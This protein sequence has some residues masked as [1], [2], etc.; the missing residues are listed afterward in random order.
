[1]GLRW[2]RAPAGIARPR[3]LR[4][5]MASIAVG[6]AR[7]LRPSCSIETPAAIASPA[8]STKSRRIRLA[9]FMFRFYGSRA[10][11]AT[12]TP[13]TLRRRQ[14]FVGIASNLDRGRPLSPPRC[15]LAVSLVRYISVPWLATPALAT[16]L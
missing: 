10:V 11:F 9:R 3:A 16:H 14:K 8:A 2:L 7:A 6:V 5:N 15:E 1:M 12:A 13:L 4:A